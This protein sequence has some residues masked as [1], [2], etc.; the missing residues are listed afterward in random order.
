VLLTKK[1]Q[2][3]DFL[4]KAPKD[5]VRKEKEKYDE[6][7]SKKERIQENIKKLHEAEK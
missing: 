5:V 4:N 1:L 7:F 6:I 2:I 3:E